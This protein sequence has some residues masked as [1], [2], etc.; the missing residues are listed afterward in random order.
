VSSGPATPLEERAGA[1]VKGDHGLPIRYR[2]YVKAFRKI[3]RYAKIP[4]EVWMMD[5]RADGATEAEEAGVDIGLISE[6]LTHTN[7]RT[8]GRHIR[9][10]SKEIVTIAEARKQSR[11]LGEEDG[12]AS[13]PPVR[14]ASE[15]QGKN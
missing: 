13:E 5:A 3:A 2:T 7:T 4:D 12:T 1:I 14:I 8:S 9:R 15:S 6:G 10:H 11:E